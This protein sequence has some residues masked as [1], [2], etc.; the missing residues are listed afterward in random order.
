[1]ETT[2]DKE[3]RRLVELKKV[4]T[5]IRDEEI[6]LSKREIKLLAEVINSARLRLDALRFICKGEFE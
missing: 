6:S 5:N 3:V 2:L 4:N 1:M